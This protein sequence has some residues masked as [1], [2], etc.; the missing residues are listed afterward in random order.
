MYRFVSTLF[1]VVDGW[2]CVRGNSD[3]IRI[4]SYSSPLSMILSLVAF[5]AVCSFLSSVDASSRLLQRSGPLILV[6]A[7]DEWE[8]PQAPPI[9]IR[10]AAPIE[11]V[12]EAPIAP[13]V[14]KESSSIVKDD[15]LDANVEDDVEE[16]SADTVS[17]VIAILGFASL[18]AVVVLFIQNRADSTKVVRRI[19]QPARPQVLATPPQPPFSFFATGTVASPDPSPDP[20]PNPFGTAA[21]RSPYTSSIYTPRPSSVESPVYPKSI[22]ENGPRRSN[23]IDTS[24]YSKFIAASKSYASNQYEKPKAKTPSPIPTPRRSNSIDS[25]VYRY[26]NSV[27][28]SYESSRYGSSVGSNFSGYGSV[29]SD[30]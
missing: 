15:E 1:R 5:I 29:V 3:P 22:A 8:H 24:A 16:G 26:S 20:S 21:F 27:A 18:I 28:S 25:S 23:S 12:T 13:E 4:C 19:E 6:P 30:Y 14:E 10:T 9:R 11:P 17:W 7:D 2:P